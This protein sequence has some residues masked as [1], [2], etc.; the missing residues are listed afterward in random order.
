MVDTVGN[1]SEVRVDYDV[2]ELDLVPRIEADVIIDDAQ[3]A[4]ADTQKDAGLLFG[5]GRGW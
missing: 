3:R 2:T 1:R 5:P 4:E